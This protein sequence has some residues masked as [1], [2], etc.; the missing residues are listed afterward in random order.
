MPRRISTA[1][2]AARKVRWGQ[3]LAAIV[4]LR[5][6]GREH[7]HRLTPDERSEVMTLARKSRG[8]K[9][10]LT[11]QEQK[12]LAALLR[13]AWYRRSDSPSVSSRE[14]VRQEPATTSAA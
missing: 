4:W 5:D 2:L 1:L 12:R 3:V 6:R 13:E 14:D 7:W 10:N 8:R 9:A 11:K